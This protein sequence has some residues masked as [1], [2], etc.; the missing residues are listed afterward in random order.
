MQRI[1]LSNGKI[2]CECNQN[3]VRP[4]THTRELR[5]KWEKLDDDDDSDNVYA[6]APRVRASELQF[7]PSLGGGGGGELASWR[8]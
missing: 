2:S 4:R 1:N 8:N 6:A 3:I 7:N 5:S